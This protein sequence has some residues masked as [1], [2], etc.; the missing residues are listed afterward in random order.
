[1]VNSLPT[2]ARGRKYEPHAT[3]DIPLVAD[4]SSGNASASMATPTVSLPHDNEYSYPSGD[5]AGLL[6]YFE[7][8]K[9]NGVVFTEATYIVNDFT[10]WGIPM[11][12][13]GFVLRADGTDG[14]FTEYLTLD[15]G[16]RGILW[17]TFDG[18]P[19][20]PDGTSF[21]KKYRINTC[22][23]L[24]R[25]YCRDTEPFSWPSNDCSNWAWGLMRV[26][27][28]KEDPLAEAGMWS[29]PQSIVLPGTR[30]A[31]CGTGDFARSGSVIPACFS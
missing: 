23:L 19:D 25:A 29:S 10:Y 26:M 28:I 22:P 17:D 12:H 21:V 4:P 20:N 30:V 15:F 7:S 2:P 13:H 18:Y 6:T 9:K 11:K 1:M 31:R 16:K 3:T 27:R 14:V 24:L 5:I 8:L